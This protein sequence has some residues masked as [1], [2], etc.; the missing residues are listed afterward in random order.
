MHPFQGPAR[1][2]RMIFSYIIA[3]L[4]T[5]RVDLR[6]V[7]YPVSRGAG[8]LRGGAKAEAS[9]GGGYCR[10]QGNCSRGGVP[11]RLWDFG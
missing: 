9:R 11:G 5:H 7:L 2:N 10:G 6:D 3:M 8:E 1:S 4:N